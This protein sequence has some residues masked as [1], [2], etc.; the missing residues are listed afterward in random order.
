MSEQVSYTVKCSIHG[1]TTMFGTDKGDFLRCL[2]C[3]E[4]AEN[5]DDS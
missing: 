3:Y 4:E 2:K 1:R 5:N